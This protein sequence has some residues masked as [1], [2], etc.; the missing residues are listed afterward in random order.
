MKFGTY[1]CDGIL[2]HSRR[3]AIV[4]LIFEGNYMQNLK[5][6]RNF[7][8]SFLGRRLYQPNMLNFV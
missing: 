3:G 4:N 2:K 8:E 5:N 1:V 7:Q 6:Y